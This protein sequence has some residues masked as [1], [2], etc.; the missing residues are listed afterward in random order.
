MSLPEHHLQFGAVRIPYAV[1][2]K[3]GSR[4]DLRFH[5]EKPVLLVRTPEGRLT[6]AARAFIQQSQSCI[7]KHFPLHEQRCQRRK[8]FFEDI[9]QGKVFFAG[10][11]HQIRIETGK[12]RQVIQKNGEIRVVILPG[13]EPHQYHYLNSSLRILS[14]QVIHQKVAEWAARTNSPVNQVRVKN[15]KTKWGS[16]SSKRN[17]NFNWHLCFLPLHLIEYLVIHELMHLRQM[18][19]SPAYWAEVAKYY[20]GYRAAEKELGEYQWLIQL[21]DR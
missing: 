12:K 1:E 20:P 9:E 10:E 7:L 11:W 8:A 13:D 4:I 18:N 5:P 19:H 21:F 17:L 16:C 3:Q 2:P 6:E 14:Q 15:H